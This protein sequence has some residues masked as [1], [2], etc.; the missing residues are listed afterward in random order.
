MDTKIHSYLY[1][2]FTNINHIIHTHS[3][4]ATVCAQLNLQPVNFGTTHSD[5]FYNKIPI[6]KKI[7]SISQ[8]YEVQLAKSV[9]STLKK[10]KYFPPGILLNN[11]GALVWGK[12]SQ[13]T[14]ERATAIELI[15]K[16]FYLSYLIKKKPNISDSLKKFHYF[17]KNGRF[18]FYGQKKN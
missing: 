14:I 6:S 8:N 1:K 3:T 18:S 5:Y 4:F 2:K 7:Q 10:E 15:C 16:L 9:E 13:E 12:N 11:H 17:R